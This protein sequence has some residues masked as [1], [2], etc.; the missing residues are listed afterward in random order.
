MTALTDKQLKKKLFL[1]LLFTATLFFALMSLILSP[2][3]SSVSSNVVYA[4]TMLP[5]LLILFT[6]VLNLMALSVCCAIMIYSIVRLG[7]SASTTLIV[8]YITAVFL[9]YTADM[10]VSY[11]LLKSIDPSVI[12][13]YAA[14]FL[15]DLIIVLIIAFIAYG[16][17]RKSGELKS[18]AIKSGVVIAV[19]KVLSRA[20]YDISYGPPRDLTDLLW[21][22]LYYLSDLLAGA[23]FVLILMFIFKLLTKKTAD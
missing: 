9:K 4:H 18:A 19:S 8:T 16:S 22:I 1:Y 17:Y 13:S 11:L 3:I 15:V 23:I 6:D 21:M 10:T 5:D 12:T 2:I 14:A 20:A 7:M